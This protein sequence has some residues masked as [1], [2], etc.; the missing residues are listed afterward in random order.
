MNVILFYDRNFEDV[1]GS[2]SVKRF[3][4]EKMVEETGTVVEPSLVRPTPEV[5]RLLL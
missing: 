5:K 3:G 2:S 4:D 1:T